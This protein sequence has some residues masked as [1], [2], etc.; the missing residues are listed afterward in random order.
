M[1]L[2][3]S[4]SGDK[5]REVATAL[6][7][8]IPNVIQSVV[9]W[10]SETD[11]NAG[12]RWNKEIQE[13]LE[14]TRFGIICLTKENQT[15]PWILFETGALAKTIS[16]TFVC[17]YLIGLSPSEIIQGP[18]TQFQAKCADEKGTLDIVL[19]INKSLNENP[20]PEE[21]L[22]KTFKKR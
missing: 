9:P 11:I 4:W 6:R 21:K 1:N 12:A 15:A 7:D 16:D 10:M 3:I 5:S 22:K 17:P 20:L 8:W 14:G 2:F 18:L 19:T 13:K